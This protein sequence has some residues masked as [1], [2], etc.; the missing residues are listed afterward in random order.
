MGCQQ[1]KLIGAAWA[2][3]AGGEVSACDCIGKAVETRDAGHH[4]FG[5]EGSDQCACGEQDKAKGGHP[6]QGGKGGVHRG[7]GPCD[8]QRKVT[9]Q[10][11][12]DAK[13]C[14][15]MMREALSGIAGEIGIAGVASRW[16]FV[17]K[18][19]RRSAGKRC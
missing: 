3:Q 12:R 18:A 8:Q 17:A 10:D 19:R 2:R 13:P 14:A 6:A 16:R 15:A 5:R 9:R 11:A 1:A 7:Q 4:G